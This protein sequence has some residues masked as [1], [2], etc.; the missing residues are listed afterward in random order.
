MRM[1]LVSQISREYKGKKYRKFWIN[2]PNKILKELG[3]KANQELNAE[4]KD[5]KLI[6]SKKKK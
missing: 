1:K 4:V 2:I 3:W 6:V 5:G